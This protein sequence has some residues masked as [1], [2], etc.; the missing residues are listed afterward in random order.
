M[1]TAVVT[2]AASGIGRAIAVRLL[3]DGWRVVGVDVD[4][5]GL[6]RLMQESAAAPDRCAVVVGDVSD[7]ETHLHARRK[8]A[9]MGTLT[10]WISAAGIC[11]PFPLAEIDAD[12]AR[13]MV[14]VNQQ[15]VLWGS[16][17]ALADFLE[18]GTPGVIVA[19]SSVHARLA[20]PDFTVYE[21]TKAAIEALMRGIAV[22]YG[23]RGIRAV[24]VAPG[25][26]W[27][28]IL[29][30]VYEGDGDGAAAIRNLTA[31]TPARRIGEPEEVA[32]VVSFVVSDAA[33]FMTGTTVTIDGGL[34]SVLIQQPAEDE[35][36]TGE[37][38]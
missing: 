27:T 30:G 8:A 33:A 36:S 1:K 4:A 10:A 32:N 24:A 31:G 19:I 11:V 26:I 3:A 37:P 38:R 35:E 28:P 16:A 25:A 9:G 13:Q 6:G 17:E 15:G 5:K 22:T 18:K 2:G 7:R 20:A 12:A 29:R 34:S 21:M 14:E 23:P